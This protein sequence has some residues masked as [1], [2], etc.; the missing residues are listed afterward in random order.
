MVDHEKRGYDAYRIS[1]DGATSHS[2]SGELCALVTRSP[3]AASQRKTLILTW[4]LEAPGHAVGEYNR[5]CYSG[6]EVP[7]WQRWA[8]PQLLRDSYIF[9]KN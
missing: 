8:W 2:V 9:P 6:A 1:S 3:Q 5:L 4:V 7:S